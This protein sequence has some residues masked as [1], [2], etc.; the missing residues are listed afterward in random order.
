MIALLLLALFKHVI[1]DVQD[2]SGPQITA[3][4]GTT[5]QHLDRRDFSYDTANS[6]LYGYI[7]VGMDGTRTQCDYTKVFSKSRN[8]A[9]VVKGARSRS[10]TLLQH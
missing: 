3:A 8:L 10:T 6:H 2:V 4:P 7:S 9:D 5:T 1:S